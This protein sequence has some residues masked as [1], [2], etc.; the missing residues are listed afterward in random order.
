M[1]NAILAYL[2]NQL[3]SAS[4]GPSLWLIAVGLFVYV[5]SRN[6][7]HIRDEEPPLKLDEGEREVDRIHVRWPTLRS[8]T[9]LTSRRVIQGRLSWWLSKRKITAISLDDVHSITWRRY[10]NWFLLLLG[11]YFLDS[12]NPAA[13]LLLLFGLQ[14]KVYTVRFAT[15]FAQM[16]YT[17]IVVTSTTRRQLAAIRTFYEHALDIWSRMIVEKRLAAAVGE[18]A[19]GPSVSPSD[20][21]TR[22]DVEND[23]AWGGALLFYVCAIL[24]LAVAQRL[25]GPHVSFDDYLFGP[26]YI[27]LVA[28]VAGRHR[29]DGLW[30]ALLGWIA[31]LTIKF[32]GS[33]I[34]SFAADG[35]SPLFEEYVIVLATLGLIA[36]SASLLG[37]LHPFLAGFAVVLWAVVPP[38]TST[39]TLMDFSLLT[40]VLLG[41]AWATMLSITDEALREWFVSPQEAP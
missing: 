23:F 29:R 40:K 32:P 6:F 26:L 2:E 27:G 22:G 41:V 16:P 39:G 13:L 38:A 4:V 21:S 7:R 37:R 3:R 25:R 1:T 15:P 36:Y 28:G 14:S 8:H 17:R 12:L 24:S 30:L 35:G 31:L 5:M 9:F 19:A 33:G 18:S 10:T 11:I 20:V 34:L